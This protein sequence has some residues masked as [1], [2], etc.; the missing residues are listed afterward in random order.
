M[1]LG[2]TRGVSPLDCLGSSCIGSSGV[3]H[4][5]YKVRRAGSGSTSTGTTSG[6][7]G[8]TCGCTPQPGLSVW[9]T[10]STVEPWMLENMDRRG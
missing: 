1:V 7:G 5:L 4:E 6:L 9:V 8:E 2:E 3:M 10:A